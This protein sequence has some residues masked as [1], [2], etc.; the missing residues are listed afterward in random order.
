MR[1][2]AEA[3]ALEPIEPAL[4]APAPA[5]TACDR[6]ERIE[7]HKSARTLVALCEGGA[8]RTFPVA[9][10]RQPT[11]AKRRAGD[12]RTPEGDYRI[13]GPARP[14]RFHRFV[15]I[16]Y[17]SRADAEVGR[18]TGVIGRR[19]YERILRAHDAGTLPP[20][21]T[22]LGGTVG[23]HGEGE[24]WRGS[25]ADLDWTRG[26][27]ALADEHLDFVIARAPAGTPVSITP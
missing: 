6:I 27:L 18:A 10:S 13:A 9:L 21:D 8:R 5:P 4:P 19:V 14:S 25:S 23:F 12:D 7:V 11:G 22:P 20:Q 15:Q 16:D 1:P 17:P 24:R 26:C 3:P 2:P